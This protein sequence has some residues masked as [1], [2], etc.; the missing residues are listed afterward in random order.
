MK[1][2]RFSKFL[3]KPRKV[4][5]HVWPFRPRLS[6]LIVHAPLT[7]TD[8]VV[9]Q[10]SMR[11]MDV[12]TIAHRPVVMPIELANILPKLHDDPSIW[13]M[14]QVRPNGKWRQKFK[15][16]NMYLKIANNNLDHVLLVARKCWNGSALWWRWL[17]A[18]ENW[19]C[20]FFTNF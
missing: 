2:F 16:K 10:P 5:A 3:V 19:K 7:Q 4:P 6:P 11:D 17:N 9:F 14:G 1:I 13:F 8:R 12:R 15:I 18:K 20:F